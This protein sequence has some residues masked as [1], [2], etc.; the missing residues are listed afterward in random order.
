[1]FSRIATASSA[2]KA[3]KKSAQGTQHSTLNI[4]VS[5]GTSNIERQMSEAGREDGRMN[6]G[7][8]DQKKADG[9]WAFAGVRRSGFLGV[10]LRRAGIIFGI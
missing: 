7:V 6:P 10:E 8:K 1:M 4:Q 3:Q 5:E 9:N 2:L